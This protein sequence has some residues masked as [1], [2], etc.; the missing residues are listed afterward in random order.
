MDEWPVLYA[1]DTRRWR[2]IE[3]SHAGRRKEAWEGGSATRYR[4]SP[5][6]PLTDYPWRSVERAAEKRA[7]TIVS[8]RRGRGRS[9]KGASTG[10][11]DEADSPARLDSP[12]RRSERL[13]SGTQTPPL[14]GWLA[15]LAWRTE[16]AHRATHRDHSPEPSPIHS[17]WLSSGRGRDPRP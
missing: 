8:G 14:L 4:N 12:E 9:A 15:G 10:P 1:I 7:T 13:G 2:I 17:Q 11:R 16:R 5:V 6:A 3:R